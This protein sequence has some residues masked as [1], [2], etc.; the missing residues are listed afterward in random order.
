MESCVR[1]FEL[2]G[3]S[4]ICAI[5]NEES[6][7]ILNSYLSFE[8]KTIPKTSFFESSVIS[9]VKPKIIDRII[10]IIIFSNFSDVISLRMVIEFKRRFS[11]SIISQKKIVIMLF[12]PISANH[13]LNKEILDK[14][15]SLESEDQ[16]SEIIN[17]EYRESGS[18]KQRSVE[19]HSLFKR[20]SEL[21]MKMQSYPLNQREK[22]LKQFVEFKKDSAPVLR[23]NFLYLSELFGDIPAG[24]FASIETIPTIVYGSAIYN[25][26]P[27][28]Q[29]IERFLSRLL[30]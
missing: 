1:F 10:P 3:N 23:L 7:K 15:L 20:S 4:L 18:L 6:L 5:P 14:T 22:F 16:F 19:E 29:T 2:S 21:F 9:S 8:A 30:E 13:Q 17:M 11:E 24:V 12:L 27:G 25:G 26:I 28:N